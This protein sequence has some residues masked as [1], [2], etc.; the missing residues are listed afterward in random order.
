MNN[1]SEEEIRSKAQD[2]LACIY[3]GIEH[4]NTVQKLSQ[5][6]LSFC[7]SS[8]AKRLGIKYKHVN[9]E[10]ET[11]LLFEII[12]L[13]T[14][15]TSLI[16]PKYFPTRE[17]FRKE[18]Q[19]E[20]IRYFNNQVG[21]YLV[22]MCN[23]EGM[24]DLKEITV[25]SIEPEIDF[26]LGEALNPL[27]RLIEYA[28][29]FAEQPGA[30]AERFGKYIGKSLDPYHYPILELLGGFEAKGLLTIADSAMKGVFN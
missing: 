11:R 25:I 4:Y 3:K 2:T 5:T 14:F 6:Y 28:K 21:K 9:N 30:E 20:P 15:Y 26:G 1:Y 17:I 23:R 10:A 16:A 13:A 7:E 27:N 19:Y 29:C 12:C 18:P 24:T 8:E 22:E